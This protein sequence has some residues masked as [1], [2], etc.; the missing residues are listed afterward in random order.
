MI[1]LLNIDAQQIVV[2]DVD[3]QYVVYII[4]FD[5]LMSFD[6][7]FNRLVRYASLSRR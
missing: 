5:V 6:I 1:V 3:K 2:Y 4:S 7:C